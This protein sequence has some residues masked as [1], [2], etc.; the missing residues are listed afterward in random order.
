MVQSVVIEGAARRQTE[1]LV[2]AGQTNS[3][4]VVGA[5]HVATARCGV[6]V[7]VLTLPLTVLLHTTIHTATALARPAQQSNHV[8]LC[9]K[10]LSCRRQTARASCH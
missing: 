7:T 2:E 8:K 4:V 6:R 10:K 9:N 3:A 5:V 1:T